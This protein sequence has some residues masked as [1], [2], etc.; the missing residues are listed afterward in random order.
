MD[1]PSNLLLIVSA[2]LL[3]LLMPGPSVLCAVA[4]SLNQGR[5]AGLVCVLGLEAGMLVHVV[6]AS[7]GI[8]AIVLSSP[9]AFDL[10]R[11]A[12]A[13]YLIHLGIRTW[14]A[15]IPA[16]HGAS[17]PPDGLRRTF[18]RG[19]VVAL[20]NPNTALFFLAFLPQFV[21]PASASVARQLWTLTLIYLAL[22]TMVHGGYA[23]L[24]GSLG[25]GTRR[26]SCLARWSRRLAAVMFV[27]LG[28][29]L[30]LVSAPPAWAGR[31][32]SFELKD[33][34]R[35][36][37]RPPGSQWTPVPAARAAPASAGGCRGLE[38]RMAKEMT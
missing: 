21:D 11:G 30:A 16:T 7:L 4:C 2:S 9:L 1:T 10:V 28:L 26:G 24:A 17:P 36:E 32:L 33:T 8:T 18:G 29:N 23:L 12:G 35:T 38:V 14:R 19:A 5:K 34:A 13:A 22:A 37:V 6:G 31:P 15:R 3:V 20:L 27:G 25:P